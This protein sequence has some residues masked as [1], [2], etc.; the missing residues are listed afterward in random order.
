MSEICLTKRTEFRPL[1]GLIAGVLRGLFLFGSNVYFEF[2]QDNRQYSGA[3]RDG[4]NDVRHEMHKQ[5]HK[6]M[7][8]EMDKT[9][10]KGLISLV[11]EVVDTKNVTLRNAAGDGHYLVKVKN[12][13][14]RQVVVGLGLQSQAL[15]EIEKGDRIFVVGSSARINDRAVVFARFYG[16]LQETALEPQ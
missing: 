4:Q 5:M 6:E 1:I 12:S 2:A 8:K 7:H 13:K 14:D 9:K 10:K 15:S 16:E 3:Q 11:G